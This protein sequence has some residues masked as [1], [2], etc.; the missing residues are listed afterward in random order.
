MHTQNLEREER[1]N[2]TFWMKI[3]RIK[4]NNDKIKFRECK[5]R[6]VEIAYAYEKEIHRNGSKMSSK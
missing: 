1:N 4:E 2:E 3:G 5:K 6:K